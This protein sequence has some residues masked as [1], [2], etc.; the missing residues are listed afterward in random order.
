MNGQ[1]RVTL[2]S[3]LLHRTRGAAE[4]LRPAQGPWCWLQRSVHLCSGTGTT[5][6]FATPQM[7][8]LTTASCIASSVEGDVATWHVKQH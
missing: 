4:Y 2:L 8:V 7:Y 6:V 1:S 3:P 5:S